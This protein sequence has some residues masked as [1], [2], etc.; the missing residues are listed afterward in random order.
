[1][2]KV[3]HGLRTM[4]NDIDYPAWDR[5][6]KACEKEFEL[7]KNTRVSMDVAEQCQRVTYKLALKERA[8]YPEPEPEPEPEKKPLTEEEGRKIFEAGRKLRDSKS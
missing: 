8:K 2:L 3:Q 1:M 6:V 5:V 4:N 7:I